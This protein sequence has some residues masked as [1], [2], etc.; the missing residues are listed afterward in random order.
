M[1]SALLSFLGIGALLL[2]LGGI[3][4]WLLATSDPLNQPIATAAPWPIA[5]TTR[6]CITTMD[7]DRHVKLRQ[8]FAATVN[9]EV[10]EANKVLTTILRQ[11]IAHYA[12]LRSPV[13][14]A[15]AQRY[16]QDILNLKSEDDVK[17]LTGLT[18]SDYDHYVVLPF[19]EQESL[20]QFRQ[21]ETTDDL[22]QKLAKERKVFL[23]LWQYKWDTGKGMVVKK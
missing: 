7:W 22:Y 8:S 13:T 10:P 1:K 19:L 11:H 9:E 23:L 12:Q 16:R 6:G 21:A 18:V 4:I 2:G 15:D 20:R 3:W 14:L 5:C 17:R